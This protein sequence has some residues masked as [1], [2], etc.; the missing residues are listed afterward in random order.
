MTTLAQQ[1]ANTEVELAEA[2]AHLKEIEHSDDYDCIEL[3]RD[4]ENT[5]SLKLMGL[6]KEQAL[7][8]S[9]GY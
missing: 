7:L 4:L 3:Q 2:T 1:I 6:K 9:F 8:A 5:L